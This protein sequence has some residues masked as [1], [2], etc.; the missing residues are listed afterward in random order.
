MQRGLKLAVVLLVVMVILVTAP[1]PLTVRAQKAA[2]ADQE[3]VW[4]A[5]NV[6][7]PFYAEGKAGWDAAAKSLGVKASL[8]GPEN[9]EVQQQLSLIEAAIAKPTTAGFLIYS[10]N[11]D[12]I[13]PVLN[14]ARAAG[15]PVITGNGEL[16]DRSARDAFVGTANSALGASAADLVGKALNGK[17]KV[18]IVSFITAQNHQERVQGFKAQL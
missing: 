8:V 18:G 13:E 16:K 12:A 11:D 10:V 2:K 4:V 7:H 5:A 6:A 17:G 9:P 14:K 15:I 3:Y 1:G